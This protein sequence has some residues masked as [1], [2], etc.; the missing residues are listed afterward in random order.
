MEF[1]AFVLMDAIMKKA[2][3]DFVMKAEEKEKIEKGKKTE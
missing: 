1:S 3:D 2:A